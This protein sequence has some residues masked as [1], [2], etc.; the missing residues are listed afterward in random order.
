MSRRPPLVS[1]LVALC[2]AVSAHPRAYG[3]LGDTIER[4]IGRAAAQALEEVHGVWKEPGTNALLGQ[5]VADIEVLRSRGFP[6]RVRILD[7][8]QVNAL[9]LPGGHIYVFRGLIAHAAS[10]DELAA[11][12]AHEMG[13]MEDKDFQR[14]VARQLLWMALAGL[15]RHRGQRTAAQVS[16]LAAV[17]NSLRHSRRQEAQ[18]DAQAV[19][20]ALLAG[21]DPSGMLSFVSRLRKRREKWYQRLFLT[22]PEPARRQELVAERASQWLMEHPNLAMRLCNSLW[23]RGR[24]AAAHALARRLAQDPAHAWWAAAMAAALQHVVDELACLAAPR[25]SRRRPE[26]LLRAL[27]AIEEDERIRHAL[28]LAQSFQPDYTDPRYASTLGYCVVALLRL[29]A[30]VDAG[31]E[32]ASRLGYGEAPAGEEG[33]AEEAVARHVGRARRAGVALAAVLGE[34]VASGHGRPLGSFNAARTTAMLAQVRWADHVIRTARERVD[35]TLH[36][37]T[38]RLAR[39]R[40]AWL[41]QVASVAPREA[42]LLAFFDRTAAG[43]QPEGPALQTAIDRWAAALHSGSKP[44]DNTLEDTYLC[45]SLAYRQVVGELS[46]ARE[47]CR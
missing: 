11:V 33:C 19:R 39:S 6:Y 45:V 35:A 46:R 44:A 38:M 23:A 27:R 36:D 43:S 4:G 13:H 41:R 30:L 1:I 8:C 5:V 24:A 7:H 9:A 15:L 25:S 37:C 28:L 34:L 2:A 3:S 12:T 22:H 42:R 47:A 10:V 17:L 29:Q 21:Y 14:V 16:A 18:A 32:A 40:L 20:L 26:K 31:Y